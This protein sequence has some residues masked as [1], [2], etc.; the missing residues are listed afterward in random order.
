MCGDLVFAGIFVLDVA[1]RIV[2]LKREFWKSWINYLDLVVTLASL[3]EIVVYLLPID[4]FLFRLVRFG[5]L[6]RTDL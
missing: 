5:K 1:S 6:A 3:C 2:M 4:A